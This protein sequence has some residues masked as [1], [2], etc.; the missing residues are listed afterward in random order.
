MP[1]H[2]ADLPLSAAAVPRLVVVEST[3]STNADLLASLRDAPDAWPH[4]SV[5]VTDDQRAGRG[6]LE[7]TWTAA[8]GAAL[9]VSIVVRIGAIPVHALGWIPLIAGVAMA[10]AVEAQLPGRV[11]K[12]KWPNDVLVDGLKISGILAELSDDAVVIGAGLNTTMALSDLPVPTA[13]SFAAIGQTADVDTLLARYVGR[14]GELVAALGDAGGDADAA[15]VAAAVTARC[16]TLDGHV[17]VLLPGGEGRAPSEADVLEGHALRI[18]PA[19][20]LIVKSET[21]EERSVTAGDVVHV[22]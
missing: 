21:G 10:E 2:P 17:R 22:R 3:G 5:L 1:L 11:V 4:L 15:G 7:R 20:E 16:A 8:P 19:G 12:V 14:L 9:A 6:R 18:G 13:V